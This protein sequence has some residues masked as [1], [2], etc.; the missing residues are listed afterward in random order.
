[1]IV[2]CCEVFVVVRTSVVGLFS[3]WQGLF[4]NY[5]RL[6]E[7]QVADADGG[8]DTCEVGQQ[9]AGYGVAGVAYAHRTEVNGQDVEGGVG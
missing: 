4:G 3:G 6:S 7:E 5:Q 9:T 2:V 1:M 8:N